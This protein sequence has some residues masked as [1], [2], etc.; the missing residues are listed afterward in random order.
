MADF[1]G[2]PPFVSV[3]VPARN[4]EACI[5]AC[6]KSL[7]LQEYAGKFEILFADDASEDGTAAIAGQLAAEHAQI[8]FFSVNPEIFPALPGKQKALAQLAGQARGEIFLYCDA[9]MEMP[10]GWIS[11][12][13]RGFSVE[14]AEL[15]N[16]S[17]I[18]SDRYPLQALDWILPQIAMNLFSRLG[19]AYTA[20]GNNMGILRNVYEALGGFQGIPP[21]FTE[22][23]EL[24]RQA[25]R[26]DFRLIHLLDP[27]VLGK[28]RSSGSLNQWFSQH[29]RW[30]QGFHELPLLKKI[31]VYGNVLFLPAWIFSWL[32]EADFFYQLLFPG[33]LALK[34][35]FLGHGLWKL[36]KSG[37]IYW[38]PL[39]DFLYPCLYLPLLLSSLFRP[40]IRWKGRE[41]R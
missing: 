41:I 23:Y 33:L 35:L 39:Y 1:T 21:S 36:G 28:T 25:S 12:M 8:R 34:F 38:L 3:F 32:G 2:S 4:E 13:V 26:K 7:L 30:M 15:L 24:F 17:T 16:G 10:S 18:T 27:G 31:P 9:D 40:G 22:D 5:E 14:K 37:L 6:L 11:A 20:M 29:L 19:F